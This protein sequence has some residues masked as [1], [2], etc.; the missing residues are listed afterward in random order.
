VAVDSDDSQEQEDS[1][2]EIGRARADSRLR[3]ELRHV[4]AEAGL[5]LECRLR[6]RRSSLDSDE[7]TAIHERAGRGMDDSKNLAVADCFHCQREVV[8]HEKGRIDG[9][10]LVERE[11]L[12][13]N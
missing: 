7:F 10:V 6:S 2:R 3:R 13:L 1:S 12:P 5:T 8:R 9:A 11:R 4:A